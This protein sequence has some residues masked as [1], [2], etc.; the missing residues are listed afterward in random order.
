MYKTTHERGMGKMSNTENENEYINNK[1]S[2]IQK[3][4]NNSQT[5]KIELYLLRRLKNKD[6]E[7]EALELTIKEDV[8][9]FL[10]EVLN[11]NLYNLSDEN[12][13]T[14]SP[15]NDEFHINDS[16]ASIK[17]NENDQLNESFKKMKNSFSK[18]SL[19]LK[20]AKF[21]A[22]KLVDQTNGKSCYVFYYQ[23]IKKAASN[24]KFSFI[25]TENYKLIDTDLIKIGGFLDFIIDENEVLYIHAPRPFEWAFNYE[26]HINKKRDENI[27]KILQKDIFLSE[28]SEKIFKEEA[29]KYLRSR[30]IATINENTISNL[31]EHFNERIDE[32]AEL[33]NTENDSLGIITDLFDFIDFD[34]RK[35]VITEDNKK[36]MKAVFYLLQNKIVESFL[37]KEFKATIGYLEKG[38]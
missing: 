3:F 14:V 24:K 16:L 35:I 38:D 33:R 11:S 28:E 7:Y 27:V 20:N 1:E 13:F 4:L 21:Q 5:I 32:L 26:D 2:I 30:S 31:E 10:K 22:I 36:D 12:E 25:T 8:N 34:K 29:S 37:T 23:G 6:E 15:Y 9:D 19:T 17:L 18:G